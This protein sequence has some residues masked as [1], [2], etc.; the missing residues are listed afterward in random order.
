MSVGGVS[1]LDMKSDECSVKRNAD[2]TIP[3]S[4]PPGRTHSY[5]NAHAGQALSDLCSNGGAKL[6]T[7]YLPLSKEG[8]K[9]IKAFFKKKSKNMTL[10]LLATSSR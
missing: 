8:W 2:S 6:H 7:F 5:A 9:V 10:T 4:S 3:F 1:E